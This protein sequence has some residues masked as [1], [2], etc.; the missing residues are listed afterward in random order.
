MC[1]YFY[2]MSIFSEYLICTCGLQL[3]I[4]WYVFGYVHEKNIQKSLTKHEKASYIVVR[5]TIPEHKLS[6]RF[7]VH[8]QYLLSCLLIPRIARS[9]V[10][11]Y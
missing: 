1:N 9:K 4:V 10:Y 2:C 8:R 6:R 5:I 11:I 7:Q 3:L